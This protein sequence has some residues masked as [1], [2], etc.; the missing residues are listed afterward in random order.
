MS[1]IHLIR[2][3]VS[4]ILVLLLVACGGG[5]GSSAP[6]ADTS[7]A[8]VAAPPTDSTPAP[9]PESKPAMLVFKEAEAAR[10]LSQ[11]TFGPTRTTIDAVVA[12]GPEA[13]LQE[14]VLRREW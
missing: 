13:W 3:L 12:D 10:F 8:P 14:P 9:E 6:A 7:P 5:G 1:V 11:A 2:S 4:A